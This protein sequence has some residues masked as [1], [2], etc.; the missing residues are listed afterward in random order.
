MSLI[1]HRTPNMA[2]RPSLLYMMGEGGP[3]IDEWMNSLV[4]SQEKFSQEA[5]YI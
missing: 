5:F 4:D 2:D 1:S 3:A